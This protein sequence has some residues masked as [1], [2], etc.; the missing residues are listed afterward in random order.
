MNKKL[1]A[2][3]LNTGLV[4]MGISQSAPANAQSN[5]S[6][7]YN[8]LTR[9]VWSPAKQAWCN[10]LKTLQNLTYD[11][12][13]T[14]TVSLTNG[15]FTNGRITATL[16]SQPE[17]V[18]FGDINGDGIEDA[19]TLLTVNLGKSAR[20][21]VYL[22]TVLDISGKPQPLSPILLGNRAQVNSVAIES[23]QVVVNWVKS[24]N[25]ATQTVTQVY[26]VQPQLTLMSSL[27]DQLL[28]TEWLLED[29]GGSGVVDRLQTTLRFDQANRITGSGG[30][31]RYF[32]GFQSQEMA[33]SEMRFT[34]GTIGSTQKLCPPA[35]MNQETRYFRALE[36]SQRM[37][38]EG[39]SL[40]IYS[41]GSTQPLKFSR[42]TTPGSAR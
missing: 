37:R 27:N 28:N 17:L 9:E 26:K 21:S 42:L 13:N 6:T 25:N 29:L 4:V 2:L 11:L 19:S 15:T 12:P 40:L 20:Q 7:G 8:C 10:K 5:P 22:I 16:V 34:V 30:C 31:N 36:R 39:S 18:G 14:G 24:G 33:A 23:G 1:I 41:E 35:V 32:A 38:L 3:A